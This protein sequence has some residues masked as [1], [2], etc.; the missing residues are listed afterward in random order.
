MR[1]KEDAAKMRFQRGLL[2]IEIFYR[3]KMK[4]ENFHEEPDLERHKKSIRT[5]SRL[6]L[7]NALTINRED[8]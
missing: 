1:K 6:L 2:K 3:C 5:I 7:A 8:S 4:G